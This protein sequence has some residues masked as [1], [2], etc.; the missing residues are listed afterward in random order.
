MSS[1]P[2]G[3]LLRFSCRPVASPQS[4]GPSYRLDFLGRRPPRT[5]EAP[6]AVPSPSR[7]SLLS[8]KQQKS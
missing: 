1:T 4:H 7:R 5:P 8:E 3:A 6:A 2:E